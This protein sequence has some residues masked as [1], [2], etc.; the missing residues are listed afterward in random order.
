MLASMAVPIESDY[1][2]SLAAGAKWLTPRDLV[3]W[4]TSNV[5]SEYF[6]INNIEVLELVLADGTTPNNDGLLT[7]PDANSGSPA[8][9]VPARGRG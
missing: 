6:S 1:P 8:P 4:T 2:Q 3:A 9:P 5:M 7:A